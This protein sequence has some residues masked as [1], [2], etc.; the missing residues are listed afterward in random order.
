VIR[1]ADESARESRGLSGRDRAVLYAVACATGF[2]RSELASLVPSA[3]ALNNDPPTVTLPAAHAQYGR[4][5]VQP[6][7]PEIVAALR[8]YLT[9][10]PADARV[11]PGT[12]GSR[13]AEMFASDLEA[14][15]IPYVTA[16][17]DGPLYADFHGLRHSF[18]ALL[19]QAGVTLKEAM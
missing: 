1:S 6:L 9:G 7:P 3:F 15:G 16:G 4:T 18:I 12:C 13:A 8:E 19:D 17:P 10:R 11:W 5:A 14:A 2:R